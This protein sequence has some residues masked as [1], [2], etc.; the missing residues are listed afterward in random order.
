M[1]AKYLFRHRDGNEMGE[2]YHY[3]MCGLDSIYLANG[4]VCHQFADGEEG[5]SVQDIDDLH[6]AIGRLLMTQDSQLQ[7][8][9]LLW[10]RTHLDRGHATLAEAIGYDQLSVEQ[11]EAGEKPIPK[12]ASHRVRELY[13]EI[14]VAPHLPPVPQQQRS[15]WTVSPNLFLFDAPFCAMPIV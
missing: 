10:F 14:T 9:E 8:Q 15:E 2:P 7:S 6:R 1:S 12:D 11:W 13:R 4:Y 3:L 5:V